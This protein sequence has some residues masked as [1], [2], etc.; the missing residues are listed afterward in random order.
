MDVDLFGAWMVE[1]SY[2]RVGTMGNA[3]IQSFANAEDAQ[4]QINTCLR[5]RATAPRR[6]G[7]GYQ[8][9]R[10]IGIAALRDPGLDE[11]LRAWFPGPLERLRL[12][13]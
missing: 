4:V 2:G 10:V 5:K 3:K 11:R 12:T 8:L 9:Q 7:V 6:I 1:M 13:D